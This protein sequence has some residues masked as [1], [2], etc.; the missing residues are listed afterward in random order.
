MDS[1]NN[2]IRMDK[3]VIK[4]KS[5]KRDNLYKI[6]AKGNFIKVYINDI[7]HIC[8]PHKKKILIQTWITNETWYSI[9]IEV[10]GQKDLYEY[11][12]FNKFKSIITLLDSVIK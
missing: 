12:D 10:A 11:D 6:T 9:Q 4:V 7:L 1:G 3:N 5:I 8:I 2:T